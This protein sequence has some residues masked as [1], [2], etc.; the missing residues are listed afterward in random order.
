MNALRHSF[1]RGQNMCRF[2]TFCGGMGWCRFKLVP[3]GGAVRGRPPRLQRRAVS[4]L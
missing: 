4:P 2:D 1:T 3:V